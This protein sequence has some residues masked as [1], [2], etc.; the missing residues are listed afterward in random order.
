[1]L[2]LELMIHGW[3][4]KYAQII[5]EFGYQKQKDILAAKTL[6]SIITRPFSSAKL[7]KI[8]F[9]KTIFVIG[10]GPSLKT[11]LPILKKYKNTVKICADTA[12]E[13]LVK[14]G[15]KPEIIVTDLDGNLDLIKKMS[16]SSAII[17]HAHGDNIPKLEFAKR[18]QNCVGTTQTKKVGKIKNYGGFTDGDRCVFLANQFCASKIFLF[19]MDFG[20]KIGTYSNTKKAERKIKQKK[21]AYAKMLLEWLAPKTRSELFT[22]S[23]P[24]RGFRKLTYQQLRHNV[25]S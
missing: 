17:V 20:P 23:M 4:A 10:S 15:I 22:L 9:G 3:N 16:K 7:K 14:N 13:P 1:M 5:D 11:A 2:I 12:L 21:L 18:F 19:G 8:I 25:S 24:I 6:D